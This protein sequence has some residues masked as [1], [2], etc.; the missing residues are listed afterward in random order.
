MRWQLIKYFRKNQSSVSGVFSSKEST[1][2]F[3][4][5]SLYF[6]L[7]Y[8]IFALKSILFSEKISFRPTILFITFDDKHFFY[9]VYITYYM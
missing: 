8:F 7:F 6:M 4:S 5:T 2:S 9:D 3:L 1:L